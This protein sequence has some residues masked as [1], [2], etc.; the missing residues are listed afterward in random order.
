MKKLSIVVCSLLAAVGQSA[1]AS[2]V[3]TTKIVGVL[4]GDVYGNVVFLKLATQPSNIPSCQNNVYAYAFDS[5]TAAGKVMLSIAL[6]AQATGKDVYVNG[7]D[8][9]NH[10]GSVES[11]R[12]IML[13][14]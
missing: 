5:T 7:W 11:L 12:Q 1:S 10:Y 8:A 6:T 3:L 14:D 2:E 9:C 4:A 13:K